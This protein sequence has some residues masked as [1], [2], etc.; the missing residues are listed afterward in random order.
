MHAVFT[1]FI[2]QSTLVITDTQIDLLQVDSNCTGEKLVRRV[3]APSEGATRS[4]CARELVLAV[5]LFYQ[6]HSSR[7]V[8]S[9]TLTGH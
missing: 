7:L 6:Y 8:A 5:T 3:R 4:R 2:V 1:D 9:L